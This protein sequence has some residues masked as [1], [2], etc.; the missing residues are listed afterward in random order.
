GR[1]ARCRC[2]VFARGRRIVAREQKE[3]DARENREDADDDAGERDPLEPAFD[4]QDCERIEVAQETEDAEDAA[5]EALLLRLAFDGG[6]FFAVALFFFVALN[7]GDR[8]LGHGLA[9]RNSAE[10]VGKSRSRMVKDGSSG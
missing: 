7:F 9:P 5:E 3:I 6:L 1:I 2:A 4:L 8:C 10:F